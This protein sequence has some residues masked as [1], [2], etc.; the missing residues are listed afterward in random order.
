MNPN[1]IKK[2]RQNIFIDFSD[3]VPDYSPNQV[4]MEDNELLLKL[5]GVSGPQVLRQPNKKTLSYAQWTE[6]FDKFMI[7]I[8]GGLHLQPRNGSD[9]QVHLKDLLTYR[10]H[11]TTIMKEGGDWRGYDQHFRKLME[12]QPVS[13]AT[14][15]FQLIWHY[16]KKQSQ[17][18]V[19]PK[20]FSNNQQ[21]RNY[22]GGKCKMF[23]SPNQRCPN[24]SV[25][26][27]FAHA[28]GLCSSK[29]HPTYLCEQRSTGDN[30]HHRSFQPGS[31]ATAP[32]ASIL[33][34][35]GVS[36]SGQRQSGLMIQK[37]KK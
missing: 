25:S 15:N 17:Q 10:S 28:C 8:I 32:G 24:N 6:A 20:N 7:I 19:V 2:I 14:A 13:W 33:Q 9:V 31:R 29:S 18:N 4:A 23:N 37:D 22:Q 34:A 36:V 21:K 5:G 35:G 27:R 12:S 16:S 1:L 11:V 30:P 26:C 3:L